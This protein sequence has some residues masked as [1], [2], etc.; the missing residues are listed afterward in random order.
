ML[1][2]SFQILADHIKKVSIV[3]D[4]VTFLK[5]KQNSGSF[6][7]VL[8]GDE[9]VILELRHFVFLGGGGDSLYRVHTEYLD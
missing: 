4:M 3:S 8:V 2:S 5:C 7:K 6:L 1:C 9:P